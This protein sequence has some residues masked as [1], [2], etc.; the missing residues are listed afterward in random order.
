MTAKSR[1]T[2]AFLML[3]VLASRGVP[4]FL[5]AEQA[6][7]QPATLA[8]VQELLD[9]Y[10]SFRPDDKDLAIFQL[11]WVPTLNDAKEKAAKEARPIL[12]IV[13]TNSYGN[14]YTGH[15]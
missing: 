5:A 12:L 4:H 15:C 14:M 8:D 11:D 3:G 1:V 13:V 7:K 10:H 9:K 6:D 2:A